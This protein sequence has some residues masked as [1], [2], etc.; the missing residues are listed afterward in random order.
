VPIVLAF[1]AFGYALQRVLINP[2]I[3]RP[4]HSQF[5]LLLAVALVLVNGLG[6]CPG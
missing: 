3:S 4:E 2:F 5:M 6:F 1:F